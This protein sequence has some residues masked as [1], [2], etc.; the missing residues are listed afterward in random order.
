MDCAPIGIMRPLPAMDALLPARPRNCMAPLAG[1]RSP[2]FMSSTLLE[3]LRKP[4]CSTLAAT[5]WCTTVF[6]S[7]LTMSM[8]SSRWSAVCSSCGSDSRFSCDRRVPLTK[9]PLDDLTSRIQILPARS[10]QISACCRESTLLSKKPLAGVGI[11]FWLVW[12]P[13]RSESG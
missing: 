6:W 7:S 1:S 13:M 5:L 12:R 11:V 2:K 3:A 10:D 8:P 4:A 9:V